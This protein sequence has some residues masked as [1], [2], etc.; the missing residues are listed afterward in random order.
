ME[1]KN[2]DRRTFIA[3]AGA[4]VT[5]PMA[6]SSYARIV[7]SND[8]LSIGIIGS[9]VRGT[10]LLRDFLREADTANAQLTTVCDIWRK[11]RETAIELVEE[12]QGTAPRALTSYR[13]LLGMSDID[14]VIIATI[15]HQHPTM[16]RHAAEAGKDAYVEKPLA[17]EFEDLCQACDAVKK[18]DTIVQ[19]GT[20]LRSWPTF[21]GVRQAVRDGGIG[22]IVKFEQV[23]NEYEPYW[24]SREREV[25]ER[26]TD[27]KAFLM[28]A[29]YRPWDPDVFSAW[30]GYRPFSNG[31]FGGY[32]SHY[33]DLIHYISGCELPH[34]AV[35]S[36]GKYI[37][38][39][40]RTVPDSVQAVFE[41][42]AGFQVSY[43]TNTGCGSGSYTRVIGSK[44][45]I[46]M[47]NWSKPFITGAGSGHPDAVREQRDIEPVDHDSHML[48]W[49]KC[50]R[51]HKQPNAN[52]DAG[53]SHAVTAIM[54]DLSLL[55]GQRLVYDP[56][57]REIRPG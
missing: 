57:R 30:M 36:G 43:C 46:D 38:H 14:G 48:D 41:Y 39:D 12:E 40:Q 45:M 11:S 24:N 22:R 26:D 52:I 18:H 34:S 56:S 5:V 10:A 54:A 7:G 49:L 55:Q 21:T 28:H 42:P 47:T 44:G 35:A 29:P 6:A 4:S 27:W 3:G 33:T 16:L 25:E 37:W 9:G 8:R 32:M 51:A 50:I 15:D 53:F 23:R 31:A 1:S 2:I 17:L 20:Q 13:E 19:N